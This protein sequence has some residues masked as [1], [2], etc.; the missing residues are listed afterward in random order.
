[1]KKL[2][3]LGDAA[4]GSGFGKATDSILPP[5][6]KDYRIRV[7]GINYRGEPRDDGEAHPYPIHPASNGGDALGI[8]QLKKWCLRDR[9]DL[10]VL[11]SNPWNIPK[12][13]AVIP[14]GIPVV[15]VIAVEGKN[16][17]GSHL[18]GLNLAIFWTEFGRRDAQDTGMTCPSAVIPLGVDL[19]KYCPGDMR[20]ARTFLGLPEKCMNSWIVGN[21]NRNQHRKRLD[22][23]ISYFAKWWYGAGKPDA[24]LYLHAVPGS[25]VQCHI[26][27]HAKYCGINDDPKTTRLIYALPLD[28]FNGAPEAYVIAAY[29]AFDLGLTTAL[30]EGWGLTAMEMLACGTPCI[31]GDFAA[32]AEWARNAMILVPCISEGVMPDVN[33]LIGSVPSETDVIKELDGLYLN[34]PWMKIWQM[35]SLACVRQPQYRWK[36]IAQEYKRVLETVG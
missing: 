19:E 26:E 12:Y 30:G 8:G 22:L 4:C 31:G 6:L 25:G 17:V 2:L 23:T 18:N 1:M 32:F 5:L 24:Y 35:R 11:Q 14:E 3:W 10:I 9:P 33:T 29:R 16:S 15:G 13:L 27:A 20:E 21:V 34:D 28:V 7:V 36:N